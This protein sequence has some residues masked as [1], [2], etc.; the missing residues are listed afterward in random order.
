MTDMPPMKPEFSRVEDIRQA[1]G[2]TIT[3]TADEAER[4]AL[5]RRFA[6]VRIDRLEAEVTLDR[7]GEAV[8]ANGRLRADI[9]QSCAVSAED[10]PVSVNEPLAFRFVPA[11]AD[12]RPDEEIELD[13][14]DCDE[15]EFTGTAFDVGE[16]VAQS[17]ALAIDPFATGPQAE[18]ARRKAGLLGEGAAGP[19]AALAAL[20]KDR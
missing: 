15:I 17:L 1:D 16:A 19:F 20:K 10:L 18:E 5:S 4:A 7:D 12:H 3:L 11:S 13:A 14:G 2:R 6:I 9:V 8:T